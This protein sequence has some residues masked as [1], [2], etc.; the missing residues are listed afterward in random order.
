MK[1]GDRVRVKATRMM[2]TLGLFGKE[3]VIKDIFDNVAV[4]H[5]A[6]GEFLAIA[7]RDL[8]ESPQEPEQQALPAKCPR[9]CKMSDTPH[10][11]EHYWCSSCGMLF[12]KDPEEGGDFY[13]DPKRRSE[14]KEK[15]KHGF[16]KRGAKT[17][18]R[19]SNRNWRKHK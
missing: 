15:G 9:C 11:M 2:K 6:S 14:L 5:T 10:D 18:H 3:F 7:V 13:R 12:D 17:I 8:V 1:P 16:V 19:V 4:G